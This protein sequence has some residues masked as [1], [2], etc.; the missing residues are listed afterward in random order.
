[1]AA[2]DFGAGMS[3]KSI[4]SVGSSIDSDI[5]EVDGNPPDDDSEDGSGSDSFISAAL[6]ELENE[7]S[8][9]T[10]PQD[11]EMTTVTSILCW[12]HLGPAAQEDDEVHCHGFCDAYC[13]LVDENGV[14]IVEDNNRKV[15][16]LEI[17]KTLLPEGSLL[18]V[19]KIQCKLGLSVVNRIISLLKT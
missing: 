3:I 11:R 13:N 4:Q 16:L 6:D 8:G 17:I 7:K 19:R 12:S 9:L 10:S 2:M 1:M 5:Q 15:R 18:P 14:I